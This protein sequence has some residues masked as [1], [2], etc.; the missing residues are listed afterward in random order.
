MATKKSEDTGNAEILEA[1]RNIAQNQADV[2]ER[3]DEFEERLNDTATQSAAL[4]KM[5]NLFYDTDDKHIQE[6]SHISPLASRPFAEAMTLDDLA[7]DEIRD[8]KISLNRLLILNYLRLQRSVRGRHF[9]LG[10][11]V[12]QDQVNAEG[13][14]ETFPEFEAGKE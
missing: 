11:P 9:A 4:L 1:L 10:V 7:T 5:V 12:L 6:L 2:N 14:K 8:G 13:Q 3:L